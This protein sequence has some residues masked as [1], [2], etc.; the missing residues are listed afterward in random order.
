MAA[1]FE[2]QRWDDFAHHFRY[3]FGAGVKQ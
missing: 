1:E 3:V 2:I